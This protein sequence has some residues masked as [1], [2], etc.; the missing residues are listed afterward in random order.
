MNNLIESDDNIFDENFEEQVSMDAMFEEELLN[1]REAKIKAERYIK[2]CQAVISNYETKI[3]MAKERIDSMEERT[4][5]MMYS[6]IKKN[7][8]KGIV[9]S[10]SIKE[11]DKCYMYSIPS[12]KFLIIKPEPIVE[13]E[14]KLGK[15][16]LSNKFFTD[17]EGNVDIKKLREEC[18]IINGE[19]VFKET[20][21][22]VDGMSVGE[23]RLEIKLIKGGK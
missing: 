6:M 7:I 21:E 11:N 19:V 3:S 23:E 1:Y 2:T 20:G 12:A 17:H 16:M 22:I 9:G 4:K 13:N 15:W 14:E 10:E 5:L 18:Q 8:T